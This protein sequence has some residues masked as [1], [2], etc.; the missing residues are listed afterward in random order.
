MTKKQVLNRIQETIT[1]CQHERKEW[2]KVMGQGTLD[3][4]DGKLYAYKHCLALL[5]RKG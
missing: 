3:Y 1:D 5:T 2:E 4:L